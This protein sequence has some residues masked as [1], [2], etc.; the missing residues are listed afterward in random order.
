LLNAIRSRWGDR[1]AIRRFTHFRNRIAPNLHG[2]TLLPR[3]NPRSNSR[4]S[5]GRRGVD[6]KPAK[7][8][9]IEPTGRFCCREPRG[10]DRGRRRA[11]RGRH[12]AVTRAGPVADRRVSGRSG[13]SELSLDPGGYWFTVT[14]PSADRMYK[15]CIFAIIASP[16]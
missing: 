2:V 11:G 12:H 13:R 14:C 4:D 7:T 3:Q 6:A 1:T 10:G 8:P 5:K 16:R 9:R 15:Q